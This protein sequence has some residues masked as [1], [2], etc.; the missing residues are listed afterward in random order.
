MILPNKRALVLGGRTGLLGQALV[1]VLNEQ[2]WQVTALGRA[3]LNILDSGQMATV[4]D[5]HKP[6]VLFNTVAYTQVD[7]AEDE[8]DQAKLFNATLPG[9]LA[10]AVK[11]KDIKLVQFSTDFVFDGKQSLRPYRPEDAAN[12]LSVYGATKLAGEQAIKTAKI[13]S[14]I[15]RT[16]WLFGP[17]KTNFVEKIT[18]LAQTRPSLNVVHDQ[19]GSPTYTLDLARYSLALVEAKA[20]GLFHV[21]NSGRASWCELASKA[22]ACLGLPCQ[23]QAITTDQYPTKAVRPAFSVL[24]TSVLTRVTGIT[25]RPWNEALQDYLLKDGNFLV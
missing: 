15:L 12:P 21:V 22:V 3:D 24:D 9:L 5:A 16:A 2:D 19:I 7:K 18:N 20:Q 25:P 1:R 4:L 13:D 23:V 10:Q 17:Y 14:L 8:P 6:Q 11:N